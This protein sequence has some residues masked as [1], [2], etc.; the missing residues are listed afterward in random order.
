M[1]RPSETLHAGDLGSLL[2]PPDLTRFRVNVGVRTFSSAASVNVQYGSRTQSTMTFPA[3]TFQQYSL[4][5]FGDSSPVENEQ[6]FFQVLSGNAIIYLS[7]TDNQTND[8]SVR[9]ARQE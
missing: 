3:N 6:I 8:S 1:I 7:T 9:F 4:T 5:G 2:T